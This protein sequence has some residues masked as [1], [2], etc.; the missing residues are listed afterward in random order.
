MK[1]RCE[2]VGARM[3][4]C[5]HTASTHVHVCIVHR[6]GGQRRHAVAFK[7]CQPSGVL[8]GVLW[9]LSLARP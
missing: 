1:S 5:A 9:C 8:A 7:P 6:E 3:F 2:C 4:T